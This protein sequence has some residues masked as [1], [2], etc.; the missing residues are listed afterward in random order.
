M[1]EPTDKRS[2]SNLL[3]YVLAA[4]ALGMVGFI[5]FLVFVASLVGFFIPDDPRCSQK[6]DDTLWRNEE[7]VVH[8]PEWPP[9]LCMVDD[10]ISSGQLDGMTSDE[11]VELLGPP[12]DKSFPY[13]ATACDIHYYLGP[14]SGGLFGSW[15]SEWLF[16]TFG[17]D[18]KVNRYWLYRD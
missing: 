9:R 12:H 16:I 1:A 3:Y 7:E 15:D 5:P 14:E 11:V 17:Y 2:E 4:L 6:F 10:I 8:D 13:G 18:S